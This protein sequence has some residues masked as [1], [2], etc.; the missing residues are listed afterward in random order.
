MVVEMFHTDKT[1]MT[2]GT[3]IG[4][5]RIIIC[6]VAYSCKPTSISEPTYV[7]VDFANEIPAL[8]TLHHSRTTLVGMY[9][10]ITT[11]TSITTITAAVFIISSTTITT[12]NQ[13]LFL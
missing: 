13:P 10:I 9:F 7:E 1:T 2:L 12:A 11:A 8:A 3:A 4:S 6:L 5:S